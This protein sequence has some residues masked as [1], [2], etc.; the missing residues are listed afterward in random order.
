LPYFRIESE[1]VKGVLLEY[2]DIYRQYAVRSDKEDFKLFVNG[3]AQKIAHCLET[4]FEVPLL[5]LG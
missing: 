4:A 3:V 5:W 2:V 1:Q